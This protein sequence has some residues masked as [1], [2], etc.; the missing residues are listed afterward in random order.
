M[1]LRLKD[2]VAFVTGASKGIGAA[3]AKLLAEE[4]SDVI[5]GY[6]TDEEGAEKVSQCIENTGRKSWKCRFDMSDSKDVVNALKQLSTTAPKIDTVI[7]NAGV[8][9]VTPF[10]DITFE[11]WDYVIHANLNG[12]FYVLKSVLPLLNENASIVI[13][14]SVAAHT[15]VPHHPHYAAA[16]AGLVNLTKSAARAFAPNVRVNCVA[17]GIT[18]TE[19]GSDATSAQSDD[20]AR[21]KLLSHRYATPEEIAQSIVY[22]ASPAAG[23]IYGATLDING[24][25]D[26][27]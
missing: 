16:K 6:R 26:L 20:Y 17:P 21:T 8:N 24:G 5:V 11:E 19:M 15:G 18:L 22:M 1:D 13:V 23:F 27:R 12:T 25:R 3:A 9:I 14:S 7:L 4:G 2:K 10:E